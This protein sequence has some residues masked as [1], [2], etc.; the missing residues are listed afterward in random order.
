[1]I[2]NLNLGSLALLHLS[3][4][5]LVNSFHIL[6][7]TFVALPLPHNFFHLSFMPIPLSISLTMLLKLVYMV[8][9][10]LPLHL[11]FMH[12]FTT[13]CLSL[14]PL[15]FSDLNLNLL[16]QKKNCHKSFSPD[17]F[18]DIPPNCN[19]FNFQVM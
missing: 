7:S 12:H 19:H 3:S 17:F 5:T 8:G 1:M 18:Y 14:S 4:T 2:L 6:L 16:G 15:P 13:F 10:L 11:S 9:F